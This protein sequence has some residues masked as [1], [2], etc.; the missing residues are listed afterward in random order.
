MCL[1]CPDEYEVSDNF[2]LNIKGNCVGFCFSCIRKGNC[3]Q[4]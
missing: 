4:E 1:S 2:K 3:P